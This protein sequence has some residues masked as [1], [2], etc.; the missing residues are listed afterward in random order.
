MN[1]NIISTINAAAEA[2]ESK[3]TRGAWDHGVKEYALELLEDVRNS[4]EC[5]DL[6]RITERELLN[7]AQNWKEYS[8]GG[9]SLI[10]DEQIAQRLCTATELK[11][12]DNGRKAPNAREQWLDVQARALYQAAW[13][14]LANIK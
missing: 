1:N 3:K 13:I 4:A 8:Q 7:G 5:G 9:C 10:Y 2:I 14:V 11:R 6:F 12:T